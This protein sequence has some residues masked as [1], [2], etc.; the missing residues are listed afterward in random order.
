M[1]TIL[2]LGISFL[3]HSNWPFAPPLMNN[4]IGTRLK[5]QGSRFNNTPYPPK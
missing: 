1:Q 2:D 4:R 3:C 5:A